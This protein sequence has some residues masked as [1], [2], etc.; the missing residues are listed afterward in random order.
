M[1]NLFFIFVLFITLISCSNSNNNVKFIN[2]SNIKIDSILLIGNQN[3]ITYKE[4]FPYIKENK[5]CSVRLS[6]VSNA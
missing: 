2:E 1:K 3:A 6:T 5:A 4:I